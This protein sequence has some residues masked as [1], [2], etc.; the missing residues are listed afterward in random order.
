MERLCRVPVMV[1]DT[2]GVS[3]LFLKRNIIY[4]YIHVCVL[5][6]TAVGAY[7][8]TCVCVC[9]CVVCVLCVLSE[10]ILIM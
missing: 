9:V 8:C 4:G 2:W 3:M 6:Y 1:L 10:I 7:M 5:D